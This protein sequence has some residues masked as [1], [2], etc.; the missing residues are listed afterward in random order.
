MF[1]DIR[2]QAVYVGKVYL[3]DLWEEKW[4]YLVQDKITGKFWVRYG[5]SHPDGC[6]KLTGCYDC[7]QCSYY[8]NYECKIKETENVKS[9][10]FYHPE[11]REIISRE[12][13]PANEWELQKA[14]E[15][16]LIL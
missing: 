15:A 7:T 1:I 5:T 4:F 6:C 12:F 14:R 3:S 11:L 13:V 8:N 16:G 9:F 2:K 10:I